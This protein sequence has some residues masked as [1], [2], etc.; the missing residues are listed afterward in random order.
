MERRID[1]SLNLRFYHM[2]NMEVRTRCFARGAEIPSRC[3][4]V[5][6]LVGNNRS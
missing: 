1:D 4:W 6:L 5:C 3:A 2:L